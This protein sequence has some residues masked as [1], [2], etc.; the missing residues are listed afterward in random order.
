MSFVDDF[1][2]S[3]VKEH[4]ELTSPELDRLLAAAKAAKA[5]ILDPAPS[6]RA[7]APP[8]TRHGE[9]HA[10]R[11][12]RFLRH[13][14]SDN[15]TV[16][17]NST[18]ADARAIVRQAQEEANRRNQERFQNPRVNSYY[19][20]LSPEAALKARAATIA[21][22]TVNETVAAAAAVLAEADGAHD[23][24]KPFP[25]LPAEFAQIRSEVLGQDALE[26]GPLAR[27]AT[28]RFWMEDIQHAGKV[29]FGGPDNKGYKVFRN[30][31]DYGAVV[32]LFPSAGQ[33]DRS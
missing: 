31:K 7:E 21:T 23:Q 20:N 22:F 10:A 8:V 4:P 18:L 14:R 16:V 28:A 11:H 25:P 29:P 15:S 3:W 32:S 27:R 26:N 12:V 24:P 6:K 1:V 19:A 33:T 2:D 30:V 9:R 17:G 13:R 5:A